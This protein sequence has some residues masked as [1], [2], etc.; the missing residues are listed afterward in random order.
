MLSTL[1]ETSSLGP[2]HLKPEA[3]SA[4]GQKEH[5]NRGEVQ[6]PQ[7]PPPRGKGREESGRNQVGMRL[8]ASIFPGDTSSSLYDGLQARYDHDSD[9]KPPFSC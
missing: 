5:K 1:G 3:K 7:L 6:K 2:S 4:Q 9:T 8:M